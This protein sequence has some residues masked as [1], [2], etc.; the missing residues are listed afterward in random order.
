MAKSHKTEKK[1]VCGWIEVALLYSGVAVL[2]PLAIFDNR[3]LD[4]M[5]EKCN[6]SD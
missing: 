2:A 6:T 5:A 4:Q 1:G 3:V